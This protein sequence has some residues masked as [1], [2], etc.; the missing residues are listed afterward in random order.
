MQTTITQIGPVEYEL[1]ITA[2]AAELAPRI[3]DALRK[4]RNKVSLKGF[5]PGKVPAPLVRKLVG[6]ALA[7]ETVDQLVQ[8]TYEAEV[9][10]PRTHKVVGRPTIT[11]LDYTFDHDLRA[12]VRFGVTPTFELA[13]LSQES[14]SVLTHVVTDEEVDRVIERMR[15][16]EADLVPKEAE[17]AEAGD[18]VMADLQELDPATD[19]PLVGKKDADQELTLDED[20]NEDL[21]KA[22][23]GRTAGTTVRVYMTHEQAHDGHTHAHT[24]VYDVTIKDVK[25]RDLPEVDEEFVKSVSRDRLDTVEALRAEVRTSLN[26]T[27]KK[28]SDELLEAD[29]V[30][31]MR[32]LHPIP[33][34]AAVTEM[35]LDYLVEDLRQRMENR[36]PEGFDEAA[37]RQSQYLRAEADAR[38][39]FIRDKVVLESGLTIRSD[40]FEAFYQSL[41]KGP[42]LTVEQIRMFYEKTPELQ[43]R[44]EQRLLSEKVITYL[45]TRFQVVEKDEDAYN[46]E[47]DARM[48]AIEAELEARQAEAEALLKTGEE[49]PSQ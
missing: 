48:A 12:V 26:S 20:L 15:I 14:L 24:H 43:D 23:L 36:L 40:D 47:M 37:Y 9:L 2:T 41:V 22:L 35:Y 34:P 1:E 5:R 11:V 49:A 8:E 44:L 45:T 27:W 39:M 6:P 25:R 33:V 4:Q 7:Y 38:W 42:E 28:R 18:V 32:M 46:E 31:R 21:Y 13:D 10:Q 29:I 17:P 30:Y 3:E 19:A 16:E